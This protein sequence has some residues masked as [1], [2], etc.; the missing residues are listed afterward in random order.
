[1]HHAHLLRRCALAG[2]EMGTN[3]QLPRVLLISAPAKSGGI[4]ARLVSVGAAADRGPLFSGFS[5]PIPWVGGL[6]HWALMGVDH[7]GSPFSWIVG[8]ILG[9]AAYVDSCRRRVPVPLPPAQRRPPRQHSPPP[10]SGLAAYA[11]SAR[12]NLRKSSADQSNQD[13]AGA[14]ERGEGARGCPDGSDGFTEEE[15]GSLL[16][17]CACA[18]TSRAG[19]RPL[20]SG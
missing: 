19:L 3:S 15:I 18:A 10:L 2:I 17:P 4:D 7:A 1:N 13:Q 20:T 16:Q 12:P 14:A 8:D 6:E 5:R 9:L 11:G